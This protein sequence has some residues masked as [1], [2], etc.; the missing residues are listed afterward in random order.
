MNQWFCASCLSQIALDNH[1]RCSTCGSDAVDRVAKAEVPARRVPEF[2]PRPLS[3]I[4]QRLIAPPVWK[5]FQR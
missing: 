5:Y 4:S 2:D 3:R 1:G